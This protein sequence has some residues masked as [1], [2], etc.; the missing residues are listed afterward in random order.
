MA[1]TSKE[2]SKMG[3]ET[4]TEFG[5]SPPET[6]TSTKASTLRTKRK[7]MGSLL[8]MLVIYTRGITQRISG[9][10]TEKC[11]GPT[12]AITKVTGIREHSKVKVN[13]PL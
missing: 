4:D 7:A 12:A 9:K 8:G 10:D 13:L 11:T 1:V 2:P 5:K 3:N 6:A